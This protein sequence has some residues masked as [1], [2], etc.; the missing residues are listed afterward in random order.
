LTA[1]TP[2]LQQILDRAVKTVARASSKQITLDGIAHA[3]VIA[4]YN[5]FLAAKVKEQVEVALLEGISTRRY[6]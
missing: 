4:W 1:L 3:Y 2:F 6:D 5:L